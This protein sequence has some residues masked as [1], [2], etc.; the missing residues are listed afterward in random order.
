MAL[1]TLFPSSVYRAALPTAAGARL[2]RELKQESLRLRE[3]DEEGKEWS[4]RH[5]PGGYTS[6]GSLD[7]LHQFSTTFGELKTHLDRHAARFTKL[8]EMDIDPRELQL[9]R[10]WVNV[11]ATQTTHSMHIHP[12][13]VLSG[14]YY[15]QTPPKGGALKFEDPRLD[16]FM[17]SP[18]RKAGASVANLRH[19]SLKPKAGELILFESWMRHEVP[20]NHDNRERISIS[21]NYDWV[22]R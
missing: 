5:Y 9:T 12:L 3:V 14:T 21:F 1:L 11:M 7:R 13:S 22:G 18:P 8:L 20:P 4:H 16:S 19:V 15:V 17:A 2:N 10:C 6:Y